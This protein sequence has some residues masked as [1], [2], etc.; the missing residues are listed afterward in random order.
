MENRDHSVVIRLPKIDLK[1]FF[2]PR[3]FWRIALIS[4]AALFV[5]W[6]LAI[7]PILWVSEAQVEAFSST[8]SSDVQGRLTNLLFEEGDSVE[9]GQLLFALDHEVLRAEQKQLK[10]KMTTLSEQVQ[11]E[12]LRMEKAMQ[13]YLSASNQLD[14]TVGSSETIQKNLATLEDAQIKSEAAHAQLSSLQL[15]AAILDAQL[16]KMNGEA[17]FGA[18]VL[19][20]WKNLG[21][22]VS[23]GEKIYTLLDLKKTWIAVDLSEIYLNKIAIG[24]PVKVRLAAYP[25]KELSGKIEKIS[26]VT[27]DKREAVSAVK[28]EKC[29]HLTVS[30]DSEDLFLRPGLSASVGLKVR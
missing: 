25:Q 13:N 20:K 8:L 11:N 2:T 17:P 4:L 18:M 14:F 3:V 15:E 6:Y 22:S 7:R 26:P 9:K 28:Q 16:K 21:E 19:K 27:S 30:V 5:Y 12:K 29:I 23:S 24:M 10:A 1:A